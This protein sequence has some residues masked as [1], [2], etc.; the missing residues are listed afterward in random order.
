MA[1]EIHLRAGRVLTGPYFSEPMLVETVRE[2]G[3]GVWIVGMVGRHSERFRRVMVTEAGPDD[4]DGGST[5]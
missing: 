4:P 3:S 2:Y 1:G 5:A